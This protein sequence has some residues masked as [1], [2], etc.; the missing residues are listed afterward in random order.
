MDVRAV[1]YVP[2]KLIAGVCF[3]KL[4]I[5]NK[6]PHMTLMISE[7]WGAVLSNELLTA[8]CAKGQ[9]FYEAYEAARNKQLPA[10]DA[11]VLSADITL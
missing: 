3:P 11:G 5:E 10:A 7:G 8:T 6:Y 9:P 1:V 4:H 2:G